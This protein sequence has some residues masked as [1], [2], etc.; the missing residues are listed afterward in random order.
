MSWK[1]K[2]NP[3]KDWN[4]FYQADRDVLKPLREAR[5]IPGKTPEELA[6][7]RGQTRELDRQSN[8]INARRRRVLRSQ[9]SG[10]SLYSGSERGIRMGETRLPRAPLGSV[11]G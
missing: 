5:K 2:L 4:P 8:E 11:N 9:F 7:I 1:P 10:N 3:K 6:A